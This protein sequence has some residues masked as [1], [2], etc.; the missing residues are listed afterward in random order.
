MVKVILNPLVADDSPIYDQPL[1]IGGWFTKS[2]FPVRNKPLSV[3]NT[4]VDEKLGT[5]L[6]KGK[7]KNAN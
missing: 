7:M 4:L 3:S 1:V 6:I 5:K 2:S